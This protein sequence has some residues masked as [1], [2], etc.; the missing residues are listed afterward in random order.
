MRQQ[1]ILYRNKNLTVGYPDEICFAF[2]PCFIILRGNQLD[3]NLV[4][5]VSAIGK[6]DEFEIETKVIGD[7]CKI[8]ISR[9]LEL[10]FYDLS[11]RAIRAKI[12]LS[13]DSD[14]IFDFSLLVVWGNLAV[15]EQF[16][17]FG[18]FQ[19]SL[20]S[21]EYVRRVVWFTNYPFKVSLFSTSRN[22]SIYARTDNLI[23]PLHLDFEEGFNDLDIHSLVDVRRPCNELLY[24]CNNEG[25][26]QISYFDSTFDFTFCEVLDAPIPF[27]GNIKIYTSNREAGYYLRWI[28]RHGYLQYFLF[29]KGEVTSKTKIDDTLVYAS[30]LVDG[31]FFHDTGR[32]CHI[33]EEKSHKCC[34]TSL[35]ND[36]YTYVSSICTASIVD[37]Y[38][39][40]D[41]DEKEIW[42]PVRVLAGSVKYNPREVLHD[43]EL[44]F[45]TP[46]TNAQRL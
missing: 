25:A 37:L 43:L 45:S 17:N 39:G 19:N 6:T 1:S 27:G 12:S 24:R 36:I 30:E 9:M 34:A 4:A 11:K 15:G 41:M 29:T 31:M 5:K 32:C 3:F 44:S 40:K 28:D 16:G 14:V 18:V 20:T 10:L 26:E 22:T 21:D 7:E 13:N 2:N 35:P 23:Q 8:Y 42:L 46:D 38:M 33:D